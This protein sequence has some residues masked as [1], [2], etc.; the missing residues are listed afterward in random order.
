MENRENSETKGWTK[1]LKTVVA[2]G[3]ACVGIVAFLNNS[4]GIINNFIGISSFFNAKPAA[5]GATSVSQVS[6]SP[7]KPQA[8]KVNRP[9]VPSLPVT[10]ISSG[11]SSPNVNGVQGSVRLQAGVR[12]TPTSLASP[13]KRST[14]IVK[15]S[16]ASVTQIS[17]GDGSPNINNVGGD[18][19]LR[20]PTPA[21]KDN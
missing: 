21:K 9:E 20:Y 16:K 17:A 6:A 8:D 4:T 12:G 3:V 19:D 14:R 5:V 10:Q 1:L 15:R 11:N 13:G 18:V 2:V 7:P